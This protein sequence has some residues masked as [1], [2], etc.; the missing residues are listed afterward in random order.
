MVQ[1]RIGVDANLNELQQ[2]NRLFILVKNPSDEVPTTL[3]RVPGVK[4]SH[5]TRTGSEGRQ[6]V[7]E[8]NEAP[9]TVAPRVAK[10]AVERGW[11]LYGLSEEKRTLEAIFRAVNEEGSHVA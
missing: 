8:L 10:T 1:G 11:E 7:I 5:A 6:Y 2:S 9:E 3:R 4:A